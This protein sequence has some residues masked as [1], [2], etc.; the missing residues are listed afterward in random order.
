MNQKLFA[1][2]VAG[3]L[4]VLGACAPGEPWPEKPPGF[5]QLGCRNPGS[6]QDVAKTPIIKNTTGQELPIGHK[7][8]WSSSDGDYGQITLQEPLPPNMEV[9]GIGTAGQVYTCVASTWF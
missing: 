3:I 8:S 9:Q 1:M 5:V 4:L 7:I 2:L 6:H